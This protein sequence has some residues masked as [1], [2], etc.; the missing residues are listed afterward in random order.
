MECNPQH[1]MALKLSVSG[2]FLNTDLEVEGKSLI[3]EDKKELE[4]KKLRN[5]EMCSSPHSFQKGHF[6]C[7]HLGNMERKGI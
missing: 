2:K 7:L 4:R 1:I 5:G 6:L 3:E